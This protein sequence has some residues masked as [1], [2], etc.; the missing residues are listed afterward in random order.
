MT[1]EDL[2]EYR[3]HRRQDSYE[4]GRNIGIQRFLDDWKKSG[5]S[6]G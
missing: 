2:V 3:E 4:L 5:I 1:Y 6:F